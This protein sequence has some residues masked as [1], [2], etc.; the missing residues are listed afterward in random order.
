MPRSRGIAFEYDSQVYQ[1]TKNN[2]AFVNPTIDLR[3]GDFSVLLKQIDA[4]A[5]EAVIVFVTPPW[6]TAL[7]EV[8]GLDLR[9]TEPP[10]TEIM[11]KVQDAFPRRKL[12][13]VIQ[14]YEKLEKTALAELVKKLDWSE[15][16][17]MIQRC[18]RKSRDSP[19][20]KR[21]DTV[22]TRLTIPRDSQEFSV[23]RKPGNDDRLDKQPLDPQAPPFRSRQPRFSSTQLGLAPPTTTARA[24]PDRGRH[25]APHLALFR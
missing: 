10:I 13:F 12:L 24:F 16:D 1:L 20:N 15:L 21:M 4:A 22:A 25:E 3:H 17:F 2:L 18:R 11:A 23:P 6:G 19:W 8:E 9:R 5:D 14:V 7:N